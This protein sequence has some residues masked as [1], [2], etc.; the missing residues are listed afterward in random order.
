MKMREH[1]AHM[2]QEDVTETPVEASGSR[3]GQF[4][5]KMLLTAGF[6]SLLIGFFA[7]LGA[8]NFDLAGPAFGLTFVGGTYFLYQKEIP[9]EAIGTGLYITALVMILTPLLLFLPDV[10]D[11][12]GGV[13]SVIGGMMGLV[14][15]GLAFLLF[16]LVTAV[17]GYFFKRRAA[18]KL[19]N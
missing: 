12:S 15:W 1:V 10:Y 3:A 2:A 11:E 4:Q 16:A 18:K 13:A 19:K 8:L 14:T 6:M 5:W 9:S 17:V 7:A